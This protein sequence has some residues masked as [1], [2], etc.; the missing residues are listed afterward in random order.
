[1][2]GSCSRIR[3]GY[4]AE[5]NILK[6]TAV[7]DRGLMAR[8]VVFCS[9]LIQSRNTPAGPQDIQAW[10]PHLF[11]SFFPLLSYPWTTFVS[12]VP[13]W[14]VTHFRGAG[15]IWK[16]MSSLSSETDLRDGL[17]VT[18]CGLLLNQDT[19]SRIR[20]GYKSTASVYSKVSANQKLHIYVNLRPK[21]YPAVI[22]CM[23]RDTLW[24]NFT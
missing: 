8:C 11:P 18:D 13:F 7:W 23:A 9:G 19:E 3:E 20:G 14:G 4:N 1:M 10:P 5:R 21:D 24:V 15:I 12:G 17:L 22:L 16:L 2:S 6:C